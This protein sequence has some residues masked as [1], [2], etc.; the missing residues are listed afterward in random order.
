MAPDTILLV[1]DEKKM[2]ETLRA[3]LEQEGY[4]VVLAADGQQALHLCDSSLDLVITDAKM[5]NM[6][7]TELLRELKRT[8]P[9]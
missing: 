2:R 7:G 6:D 4:H 9:S 8:Q 5:P 1:D 3:I